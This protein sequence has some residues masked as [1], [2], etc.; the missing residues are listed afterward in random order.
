MFYMSVENHLKENQM[1]VS[2]SKFAAEL[3][4]ACVLKQ[5]DQVIEQLSPFNYL[6]ALITSESCSKKE[7]RRRI[8]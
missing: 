4:F 5:S 2:V 6:D 7:I 1:H 8:A 3:E